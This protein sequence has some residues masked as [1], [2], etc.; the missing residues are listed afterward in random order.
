MKMGKYPLSLD[1]HQKILSRDYISPRQKKD[2]S[3][4]GITYL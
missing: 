3:Y 1:K 4:F 2:R